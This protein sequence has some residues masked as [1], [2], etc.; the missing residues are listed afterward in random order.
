MFVDITEI[1][2]ILTRLLE[3]DSEAIKQVNIIVQ[4]DLII[5]QMKFKLLKVSLIWW[6]N[7]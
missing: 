3:P 2:R 7:V 4:N 1:E 6:F 5:D